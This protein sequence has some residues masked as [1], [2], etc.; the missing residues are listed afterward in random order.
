LRIFAEA[1][2][3]RNKGKKIAA[4]VLHALQRKCHVRKEALPLT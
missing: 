3:V 2:P 4:L 1:R